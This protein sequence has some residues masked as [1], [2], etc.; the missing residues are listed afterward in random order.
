LVTASW[1]EIIHPFATSV[2]IADIRS[3]IKRLKLFLTNGLLN[4]ENVPGLPRMAKEHKD[5]EK[6]K[7]AGTTNDADTVTVSGTRLPRMIKQ[8]FEEALQ[9]ALGLDTPS[10]FFRLCALSFLSNYYEGRKIKW[11]PIFEVSADPLADTFYHAK[12]K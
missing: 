3:A 5:D 10:T 12:R 1:V 11:P 9:K 7:A 8:E 2:K 4:H 6:I